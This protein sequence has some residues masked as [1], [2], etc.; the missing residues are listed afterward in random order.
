MSQAQEEANRTVEIARQKAE[1]L[2]HRD[3]IVQDAQ[4]R[5]ETIISQARSEAEGIRGDAD[6]Y[7]TTALNNL[8]AEL[9][10]LTNQVRNGIRTV[11]EDQIRRAPAS[12]P[13]K[14][15]QAIEK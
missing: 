8:Q 10:R 11:Q 2:V 9:E 3:I 14:A 5:A 13:S 1:D 12:L 6:D 15:E 7:V 4:R